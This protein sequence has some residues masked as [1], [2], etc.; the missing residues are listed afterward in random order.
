MKIRTSVFLDVHSLTHPNEKKVKLLNSKLMHFES[1]INPNCVVCT[2]FEQC[3]FR[4]I[5]LN[6]F[7]LPGLFNLK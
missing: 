2:D 3:G 7:S 1:Q 6:F 5:R 4:Y